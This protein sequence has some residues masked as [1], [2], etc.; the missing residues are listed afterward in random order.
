MI[1]F[2]IIAA[3]GAR[4]VY[5]QYL[6]TNSESCAYFDTDSIFRAMFPACDRSGNFP[7]K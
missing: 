5:E 7:R 6:E 3:N 4:I 1:Y 2:R